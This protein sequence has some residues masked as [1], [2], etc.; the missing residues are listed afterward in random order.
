MKLISSKAIK[1]IEW[2][3]FTLPAIVFLI[4]VGV[5]PL[6]I[7]LKMGFYEEVKGGEEFVGLK[8]YI[9]AL[10]HEPFW[11][12]TGHSFFFSGFTVLGHLIIGLGFAVL[13][14]RSIKNL[15][16]WRGLQFTP[17]LFPPAAVSTLWILIYQDQ[18][19]LLNSVLRFLGMSEWATNWLGMPG[20][21]LTAITITSIWNWYPFMTLTLLAGMQNIPGELYE[22]VEI[23]GGGSWSK[24][25]LIT[26]PHLMPVILTICLLDFILTFRFFDMAWIM[27]HGGPAKSSEVLATYVYKVAFHSYRFDRAGAIG[28]LVVVFTGVFVV[29]YLLAYRRLEEK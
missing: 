2:M 7:S 19:G 12:A 9:W 16:L 14:N 21:A 6:F 24:F 22:A 27:T 15:S 26:I 13:L 10:Q 18:Y 25:W 28:G 5:V 20:T 29:L 23:D 1:K 3:P 4:L 17:W 8:N 11:S